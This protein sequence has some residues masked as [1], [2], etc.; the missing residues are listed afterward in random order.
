MRATVVPADDSVRIEHRDDQEEAMSSQRVRLSRASCEK[1][2]DS[3]HHPRSVGFARVDTC[4]DRDDGSRIDS[5]RGGSV[6]CDPKHLTFVARDCQR[7]PL[8]PHVP[9]AQRIRLH[10]RQVGAQVRV[11]VRVAPEQSCAGVGHETKTRMAKY[12][13]ESRGLQLTWRSKLYRCR[14]RSRKS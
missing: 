14:T 3:L 6:I 10:A 13:G 8:A 12:V 5:L 9:G 1:V 2:D 4:R 7:K 11:G